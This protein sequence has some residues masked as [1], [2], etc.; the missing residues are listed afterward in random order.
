MRWWTG[1]GQGCT[2]VSIRARHCWR[3]MRCGLRVS[4]LTHLFQSAPAIAGGRCRGNATNFAANAFVSIRARHC[5]RAM[6]CRAHQLHTTT[7]VSIRARHCWRAMLVITSPMSS[8][9][10]FQ[11][12]PAIAG[13]RCDNLAAVACCRVV[14]IRARHCWR[15]MRYMVRWCGWC[16]MFQSAPAIAGGRCIMDDTEL[17]FFDVSIRARHCWRAM[18]CPACSQTLFFAVSIRARHCWRAMR[19]IAP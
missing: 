18:Q 8:A 4:G 14:S 3:A 12:A 1:T 7:K 17:A 5:W 6:R 2:H 10:L 13:G 16:A 11:S 19:P 15:A 9:A